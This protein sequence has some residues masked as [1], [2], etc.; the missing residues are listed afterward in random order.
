[1]VDKKQYYKYTFF[2]FKSL[3]GKNMVELKIYGFFKQ[4]K[5]T[6]HRR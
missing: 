5:F 4:A 3:T 1:M 2:Q 6:V